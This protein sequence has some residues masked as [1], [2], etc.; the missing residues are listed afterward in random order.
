MKN[1]KII[2]NV[3]EVGGVY[4]ANNLEEAIEIAQSECD[5]IYTRLKGRC[6]VEIE[7]VKEVSN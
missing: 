2:I 3:S 6:R 1:Y 7:S 5:D 4:S